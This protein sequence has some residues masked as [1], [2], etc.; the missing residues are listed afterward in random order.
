LGYSPIAVL[1]SL[2]KWKVAITS[3]GQRY[4]SIEE[5]NDYIKHASQCED[6][7]QQEPQ[8]Q[9]TSGLQMHTYRNQ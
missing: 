8:G 9:G 3:V 2:K 7:E 4:E 1:E 5:I 6:K